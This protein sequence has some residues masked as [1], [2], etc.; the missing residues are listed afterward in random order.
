M[1][2]SPQV[3]YRSLERTYHQS[4]VDAKLDL[5]R[6]QGSQHDTD[7][8]DRKRSKKGGSHEKG[9]PCQNAPIFCGRLSHVPKARFN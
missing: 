3:H 9:A 2:E 5:Q 7:G 4:R 1:L 6:Q 8:M